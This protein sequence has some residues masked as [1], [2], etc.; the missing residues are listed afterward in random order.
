MAQYHPMRRPINQR[1]PA[2]VPRGPRRA[3]E[4]RLATADD[5]D[6]LPD[7][8][9][10]IRADRVIM[11]RFFALFTRYP[12]VAGQFHQPTGV[13]DPTVRVT[14]STAV[15]GPGCARQPKG[16]GFLDIRLEIWDKRRRQIASGRRRRF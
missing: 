5:H 4:R 2:A 7:F 8:S 11:T 16:G 14:C 9:G 3:V 13:I 15:D 6:L 10:H 12:T 1:A